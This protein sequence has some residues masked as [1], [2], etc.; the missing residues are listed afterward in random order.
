M[1][2]IGCRIL[3][4]HGARKPHALLETD[5]RGHPQPPDGRTAGHIVDDE[6]AANPVLGFAHVNDL[7]RA[8]VVGEIEG[9]THDPKVRRSR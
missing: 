1:G 5:V 4:R 8:E 3:E 2:Q 9:I 6:N 7:G